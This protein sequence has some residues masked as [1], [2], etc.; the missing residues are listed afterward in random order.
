MRLIRFVIAALCMAAAPAL[1]AQQ[2]PSAASASLDAG[3]HEVVINGTRLWYRVAGRATGT[4]VVYLHGGPGQG[5]QS[6]AH[7]VGPHLEPHQR[8]VYL[9]QRGSG[10]S[11]RPEDGAY[12]IDLMVDDLE[13]L[14]RA[15]GVPRL[16][17]IGH[18]FGTVLAMEYGARYP[19]HVAHIVLAGG[20]NDVQRAFDIQC[21]RLERE[22]PAAYQRAMAGRPENWTAR[23]NMIRAYRGAESERVLRSYMFPN[24]ATADLLKVADEANGLRNTGE[25]GAALFRQG[26][27][28]YRFGRAGEL[29]APVLIIGGTRDFQSVIEL[30]RE[31]VRT[32][33]NGR[34]LEYE[35]NG[36]FMWVEDPARFARDVSAFL[37]S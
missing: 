25:V 19:D 28:T 37:D 15:W 1:A 10:R 30:H 2:P 24:P 29:R 8:V 23:C 17:L 6:F 21:A 22:D 12:S 3:E 4:P 27:L 35:G 5:S 31:F 33:P 34:L 26:F 18:S 14:R 13:K 11:G 32:L 16:D 20:V 9:D 36:H 7:F